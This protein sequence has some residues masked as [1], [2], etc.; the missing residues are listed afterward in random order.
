M[1]QIMAGIVY[2]ILIKDIAVLSIYMFVSLIAGILLKGFMNS[3]TNNFMEKLKK[4]GIL[5]H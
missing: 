4:S 1:R 2:S 5:R 3:I